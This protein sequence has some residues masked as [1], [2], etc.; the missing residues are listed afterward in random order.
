MAPDVPGAVDARRRWNVATSIF[1]TA[2]ACPI[3]GVDG[4]DPR[5]AIRMVVLG[6]EDQLI[7]AQWPWKCTLCGKCEEACPM[8]VEIVA[9]LRRVR[10]LRER[11]KVPGPLHKGVLMCLEKGNNL[12]IPKDDFVALIE[13]MA[14]EMAE[15]EGEVELERLF[16]SMAKRG[17]Q[18]NMSFFAFTATPKHKTLA[19]FGRNGE[20]FHRYTMRQAIVENNAG[21]LRLAAHSLKSMSAGFGALRLA[22]LSRGLEM[23]G[24]S[25]EMTG[26]GEV[27]DQ[28][29]GEF[30]R[31]AAAL[32]RTLKPGRSEAGD[33]MAEGVGQISIE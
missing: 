19:I 9:L 32:K 33:E 1:T 8:N 31:V 18:P 16:R 26:A 6:L 28:I 30:C 12:G 22:D 29:G 23:M 13:E 7:E 24:Q 4:L 27:L 17:R 2:S 15:E 25:G 10:G 3:S 14:Q 21:S 11:D 5:K 20:P